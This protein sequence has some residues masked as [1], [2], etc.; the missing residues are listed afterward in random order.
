MLLEAE[1]LQNPEPSSSSINPNQAATYVKLK[2]FAMRGYTT[3]SMMGTMMTIKMAFTVCGGS[4]EGP[5][6]L[7]Q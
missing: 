1:S 4:G 3:A 2:H 7:S 5:L 6:A